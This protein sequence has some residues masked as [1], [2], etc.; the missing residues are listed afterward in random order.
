M[1]LYKT[2]PVTHAK[3]PFDQPMSSG[4]MPPSWIQDSIANIIPNDER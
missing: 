1:T 4:M 2:A 3:I